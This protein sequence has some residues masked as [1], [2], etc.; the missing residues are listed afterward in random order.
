MKEAMYCEAIEN[1]KVRC[2]LCPHNCVISPDNTGV[3]RVRKN[4]DGVLYSLIYGKYS[5]IHPDPIEKK[6]LYHFYP[7]R[8]ILSLGTL[9]CNLKCS[10]CQNW[11]ISQISREDIDSPKLNFVT[12][13]ILPQELIDVVEKADPSLN[14]LGIAYTYNEPTIWYEFVYETARLAHEKGFK[15]ILV[16]NGFINE[17]PLQELLPYIDAMNI[18]LKSIND[19]FYKNQ[20]GGNL[21]NVLETIKIANKKCLIEI[22][23]LIIPTLNDSG[24]EIEKMVSWI[25]EE[26]G[27]SVPLHFSRYHPDFKLDII[28]TP[29]ET[30]KMAYEIAS[31][32]LNYVYVGNVY[33]HDWNQTL[34]PKCSKILINRAGYKIV[35]L[36]IN[37]EGRC[38]FCLEKI[39]VVL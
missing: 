26:L 25:F 39:N 20:C 36:N 12:N 30:L 24:D 18:D 29:I 14:N 5:S 4:I 32:K 9:G 3:C 34:C 27:P 13:E 19:N 7:G 2:L 31:K 22:T 23:N 11:S 21:N 1:S 16:T 35:E 33:Q 17:K 28:T 38:K 6:P 10:F 37:N 15:N 8:N